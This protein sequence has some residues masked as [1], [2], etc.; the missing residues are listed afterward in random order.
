MLVILLP[1]PSTEQ[2]SDRFDNHRL[3]PDDG[4]NCKG[5]PPDCRQIVIRLQSSVKGRSARRTTST[6]QSAW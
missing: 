6:G 5:P 4:G 3:I 2:T 1:M